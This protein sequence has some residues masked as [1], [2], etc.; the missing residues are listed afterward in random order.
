MLSAVCNFAASTAATLVPFTSA[1][2]TSATVPKSFNAAIIASAALASSF[3]KF[4]S[5]LLRAS[6]AGNAVTKPEPLYDV[7]PGGGVP[8][9]PSSFLL[10]TTAVNGSIVM[11][12]EV[13]LNP[14]AF[15]TSVAPA[16]SLS[17]STLPEVRSSPIVNVLSLVSPFTNT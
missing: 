5:N 13:S 7:P 17:T 9:V 4:A 6:L 1:T 3:G 10:I 16:S 14:D 12:R 15:L 11:A 8:G 2:L